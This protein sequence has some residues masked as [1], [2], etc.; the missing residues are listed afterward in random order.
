MKS[1]LDFLPTDAAASNEICDVGDVVLDVAEQIPYHHP[2]QVKLVRSVEALCRYD[3][4]TTGPCS[5]VSSIAM[6]YICLI[7]STDLGL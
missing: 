4:F 3:Q 2:S 7:P 5:D 1:I 6:L